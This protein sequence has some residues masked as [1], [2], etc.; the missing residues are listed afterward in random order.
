MSAGE[1]APFE[2]V[3]LI[4]IHEMIRAG[5]GDLLF[6][7]DFPEPVAPLQGGSVWD[8]AEVEQWIATHPDAVL[9][10]FRR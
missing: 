6:N 4:E 7:G 10:L 2:L 3:G 8:R 5:I 9:D 1:S